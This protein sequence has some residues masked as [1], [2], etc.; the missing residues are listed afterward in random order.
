MFR[1][2]VVTTV[3]L[4]VPIGSVVL[5]SAG[6][7]S[8][9]GPPKAQGIANCL[10]SSGTGTLSPPL[11]PAGQKGAEHVTFRATLQQPCP[12]SN[13]TS[14]AGTTITGGTLQGVG[15][16]TGP[17][18]SSASSCADFDGPD[19]LRHFSVIVAWSTSGSPIAKTKLVYKGNPGSVSG[20]PVDTINLDMP[21]AASVV[22]KGS[23]SS[24]PTPHLVQLDTDIPGP[25]CGGAVSTFNITGGRVTV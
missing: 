24:T 25:A 9:V 3:A 18:G 2:L 14:P 23:F 15:V 7:S 8:A 11:T 20:A 13:I 10:I 21:P 22:K 19:I 17:A 1:K 6:P 5:A 16:Y 4:L 12:N